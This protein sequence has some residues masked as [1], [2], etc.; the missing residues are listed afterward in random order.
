MSATDD[1][2]AMRLWAGGPGWAS[3]IWALFLTLRSEQD[4]RPDDPNHVPWRL[5]W[6]K[7]VAGRHADRPYEL[8]QVPGEP[9]ARVADR[10]GLRAHAGAAA[11]CGAD[12]LC[13]HLGDVAARPA[14]E[15]GDACRRLDAPHR[16]AS[17][18]GDAP[19]P[20]VEAHRARA[21]RP[22]GLVRTRARSTRVSVPGGTAVPG[23]PCLHPAS[24][25]V[26]RRKGSLYASRGVRRHVR[27]AP[28][29]VEQA[30]SGTDFRPS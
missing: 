17:T 28:P 10:D 4:E 25:T 12:R 2:E 14:A 26:Q 5:R 8:L 29:A 21:R 16:P 9:D 24:A 30:P 6:M 3:L 23:E 18:T 1:E 19:S 13:P 20:R 22:R 15:A 11:A 27:E 7:G